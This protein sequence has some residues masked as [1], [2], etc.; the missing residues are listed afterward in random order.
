[1]VCA[2][3][4][5]RETRRA[6]QRSGWYTGSI[7]PRSG[8]VPTTT[9]DP[10]SLSLRTA[11]VSSRTDWVSGIRRVTSFA[12]IMITQTSGGGASPSS[13]SPTWRS[14]SSDMAP[15]CATLRS[16]T[17]RSATAASP[18]A[19]S[20]P[21][22]WRALRTPS[23]AAVES[24]S[25]PIRSG[26]GLSSGPENS[27]PY[28][29]SALG[30]SGSP[31]PTVRFANCTSASTSPTAATPTSPRP[32]PPY[33]APAAIRR[34]VLALDTL[35]ATSIGLVDLPAPY[36]RSANPFPH[37]LAGPPGEPVESPPWRTWCNSTTR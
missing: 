1:M 6:I 12:P 15:D 5:C 11:A 8:Q 3:A 21:G 20:A 18:E 33:A 22:V 31:V 9:S 37:T 34:A 7:V 10:A 29:P 36:G 24:P 23:P 17:G 32:P 28:R 35:Q 13:S 19:S 16:S 14:R 2:A 26:P 4:S 25:M 27:L 30:G